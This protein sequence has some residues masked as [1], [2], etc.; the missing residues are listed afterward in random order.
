MSHSNAKTFFVTSATGSQGGAVARALLAANHNVHALVRDPSSA[1]AQQ[2]AAEGARIFQGDFANGPALQS[3]AANCTGA[4]INVSPTADPFAELTHAQNIIAASL[5]AGVTKCIYT[6][7]I[8]GGKHST[9]KSSNPD[10]TFKPFDPNTTFRASYWLSKAAV[11]DAV[12][13]AGF[14]SWTILQPAFL[15]PNL[16][17][18]VSRFYFK[19]LASEHVL[20]SAYELEKKIIITDPADI[21]KFAV[22][23]FLDAKGVLDGKVVPVVC[24]ETPTMHEIAQTMTEVSGKEVKAEFVSEEE[25]QEM[26]GKNALFASQGWAR[27]GW[28]D[29]DVDEVR[30]YGVEMGTLKGY[31]V[32]ERE[33]LGRGFND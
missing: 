24:P 32:R 7:V 13:S 23:A 12:M 30:G 4:F 8:N 29:V 33:A 11:Q 14:K 3:A 9:F 17:S 18:P 26:R 27:D 21:G 28:L 22:M 31:L 6:S 1:A 19:E 25:F 15:L 5:A 10:G 16:V 2:L 20:R